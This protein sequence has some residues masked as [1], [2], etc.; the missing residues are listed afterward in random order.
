MFVRC[1]RSMKQGARA[2]TR[3]STLG[4]LAILVASP[5]VWAG[6]Q[7]AAFQSTDTA[8]PV[9]EA[10]TLDALLDEAMSK[11]PAVLAKRR[12]YE[13]ARARIFAAWLPDDPAIGVDVEGQ[14]D[15]FRFDRMDNE[16]MVMQSIPFPTTLWLKGRAAMQEAHMAF[17]RYKEAERDIAWHIEQ[18]YYELF[19]AKRT[20]GA[21]E[22]IRVL[23]ERLAKAVQARYESNQAP[24]QDLLK[25][26]IEIS[27]LGIDLVE[28]RQKAHL[29]EAHLSHI[30][31][32]P[33][34]TTYTLS[35][36]PRSPAPT[37]MVKQLEA[38]ALRARPELKALQLAIQR[39]KT[40]RLLAA[41]SWLPEVTGRIEARQFSGEGSIREYDTLLGLTVPVWSLIKGAGGEWTGAERDVQAAEA[42][43]H[44]MKNEVLLA[45]HEASAKAQTALSGLTAYEQVILPQ[46]QQQVEVALSA[47]EA[48]R[49]DLL[50]LVD[51]QRML[52]D[53]QIAYYKF[54]ADYEV[55]LADLRLAVGGP[56]VR[57]ERSRP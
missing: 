51:A 25:A 43:Y 34:E 33:L 54:V 7:A 49:A 12:A 31:D 42:S 28:W 37:L 13:A 52:R 32:R 5:S 22:A 26:R 21:L 18:P 29:A 53:A 45:I 8:S 19:L 30:L 55:G 36:A 24:Q 57:S 39:A 48:G 23:A 15:L 46:A 40:S 2:H 11:S 47:Y 3:A 6:E 20:L 35:E 56:F 14:S 10:I 50:S 38:L 27:K 16:Y 44:E 41:T 4:L 17:Q 1:C 9:V